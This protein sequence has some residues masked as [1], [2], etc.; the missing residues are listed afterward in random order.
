MQIVFFFLKI[1]NISAPPFKKWSYVSV[2]TYFGYL[3]T[4]HD[5]VGI[6]Q[7]TVLYKKLEIWKILDD[8]TSNLVVSFKSL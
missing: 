7:L 1:S 3:C 2:T 4:W 6:A 8:G 5:V